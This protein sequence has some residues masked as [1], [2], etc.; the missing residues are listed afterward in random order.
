MKKHNIVKK[1]FAVAAA[2]A[3]TLSLGACTGG[4]TQDS[5]PPQNETQ[6]VAGATQQPAGGKTY[7]VAII[8]Q[9]DHASLDEIAEA[10]E[11]RLDEIAAGNGVTI[12]YE[13]TSGQ[14]DQST[15][16]QLADQAIADKVDVIIPIATAAA[17][18]AA[19]S[20]EDTKTPVVF[21]AVSYPADEKVQLIGIDH[22]TGTSDALN[23]RFIIDMMLAQN[24]ELKKVGLL[25]SLSEDNSAIPIA[26][27]KDYLTEKGI[28]YSEQT[29]NSNDEVIAAV[30]ALIADGV[31]AVFTP[32]DNVIQS[33][34]LAIYESLIDAGIPHY[35][36][37]DSFARNGAFAGSGVNYTLLGG[38]TADLAYDVLTKGMDSMEDYYL[39]EG[40][41]ITVNTETA[42]GLGADYSM[43]KDMGTLVEVQ[44]TE[45]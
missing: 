34:E 16:K 3:L 7:K 35:G 5:Q 12:E 23:T 11:K 27:A 6:D 18:V 41:I 45:D 44:T 20:A 13:T 36:G 2:A 22:V 8:K 17:K 14:N 38:Q 28:A 19:L 15:L 24:P 25:Y 29:A 31:D 39:L 30:S 10:V 33:A 32:T 26:E 43:F 37:A 40:G 21:A 4:Q 9:M 42:A 1:F